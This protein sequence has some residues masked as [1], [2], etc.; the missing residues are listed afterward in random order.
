V[1][2]HNIS[3]WSN[4]RKG[5]TSGFVSSE[6][7]RFL[8]TSTPAEAAPAAPANGSY[9]STESA[10][11]SAPS[12]AQ[13]IRTLQTLSGVN[14]RARPSTDADIVRVLNTGTRVDV[15]SEGSD[16]WSSVRVGNSSGYIRSDLL[17]ESVGPGR[18]ELLTMAEVRPL[19]RSGQDIRLTDVR[20]GRTFSVRPFS[21][22]RHADVDT[23]SRA[24]TDTKFSIRDG[25]WSWAARPVWV[26]IGDRTI[27]ASINGMPHDVTMIPSNGAGGHFCLH[28]HG[29][30]TNN[31]RYQADLRSAI[32]E[33]YNAGRR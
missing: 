33:A 21:F 26:H 13:P 3:G 14:L 29:T 19:M 20:T 31:Q 10:A 12:N 1:L 23:S 32:M 9:G 4:V 22:G 30:I 24:D 2:S 11:Q 16:G 18:I 6:F 28:F 15:L 17:G 25:R 7:L 5:G 27:A 8:V